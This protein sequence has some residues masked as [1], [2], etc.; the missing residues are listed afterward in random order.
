M[1][2][3]TGRSS[4]TNPSSTKGPQKR[5]IRGRRSDGRARSREREEEGDDDDEGRAALR[6]LSLSLSARFA[7]V[8]R[9]PDS[10]PV[11][12]ALVSAGPM[13]VEFCEPF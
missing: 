5:I 10:Y 4:K 7:A 6:C 11:S 1:E 12:G 3:D 13:V 8:L 2:V 9:H